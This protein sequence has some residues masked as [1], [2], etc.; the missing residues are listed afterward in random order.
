MKNVY[1]LPGSPKYCRLAVTE[2]MS[3]HFVDTVPYSTVVDVALSELSIL[4]IL[5]DYANKWKKSVSVGSYPQAGTK[6]KTT[7][8][9]EGNHEDVVNAKKDLINLLEP[10]AVMQKINFTINDSKCVL[11]SVLTQ[12]HIRK[13]YNLL[14]Y[15]Y[16][17]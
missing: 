5:D 11:R 8:T 13:A 14:E 9:L 3:K 12:S 15:C 1:V 10:S 7:I 17:T 16:N 2:I 4:P 6:T